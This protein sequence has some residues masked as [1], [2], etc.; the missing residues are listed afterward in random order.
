MPFELQIKSLVNLFWSE[1]E[2]KIIYK[3]YNV[4]LV[5][6]LLVEMMHSIKNNLA[7]LDKQLLSIYRNVEQRQT[8]EDYQRRNLEEAMAKMCNDI[9]V[10]QLKE[11]LGMNVN[12]KKACQTIMKYTFFP[13]GLFEI[14]TLSDSL[15][16]ALERLSEISNDQVEFNI[17]IVFSRE[18]VY[19]STFSQIVGPYFREVMNK[20]FHWNLFFKILFEIEPQDSVDD[21]EK[22]LS[23]LE[24][25]YQTSPTITRL[26]KT[27]VTQFDDKAT[28]ILDTLIETLA[29]TIILID[30]VECIYEHNLTKV[31]SIIAETLREIL[32]Q[33]P[34]YDQWLIQ[35][36]DVILEFKQNL[37]EELS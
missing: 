29:Q 26:K 33:I 14:Q 2:H 6:D 18:P 24:H 23:F 1:I 5:D 4:L 13:N 3:N 30:D 32:S 12:I 10:A 28:L 9:F 8:D 19:H 21:F 15:I 20:E 11:Q 17:P 25:I 34:T 27:L 22:F 35:E 31:T 7:L 36:E 37:L 16:K